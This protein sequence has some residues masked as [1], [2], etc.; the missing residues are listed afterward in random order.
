MEQRERSELAR[1]HA[2]ERFYLLRPCL[3][4]GVPL[5]Q[6]AREQQVP[7]RTVQRWLQRYQQLGLTGLARTPRADH[8]SRRQVPQELEQLIE[9]SLKDVLQARNA[10][11]R[12]LRTALT[13]RQ[14]VVE[15]FLAVHQPKPLPAPPATP[16]PGT[17]LKRYYND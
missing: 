7:L 14:T 17:H 6:I 15:R 12:Q 16:A 13:T 5:A 9:G 4:D 1:A 2:L 3:E 10:R 8:G 11:R